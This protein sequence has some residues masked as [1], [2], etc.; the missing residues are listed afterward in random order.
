MYCSLINSQ[1][2]VGYISVLPKSDV[3]AVFTQFK[4]KVE[5]L[6]SHKIKIIQCDGGTE[7]KPLQTQFPD[8]YFI[9]PVHTLLNIMIWQRG[10]IGI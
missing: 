3:L 5:T 8:I 9:F 2:L 1:N 7:F 10:N 4:T 6:L